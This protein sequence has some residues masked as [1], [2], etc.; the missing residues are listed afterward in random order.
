MAL[1]AARDLSIP[2]LFRVLSEKLNLECTRL[3][4][5]PLPPVVTPASE[6]ESEVRAPQPDILAKPRTSSSTL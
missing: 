1:E 6:V 3:Q 4:E 5:T 2:D